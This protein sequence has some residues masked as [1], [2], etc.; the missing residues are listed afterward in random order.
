MKYIK[1]VDKNWIEKKGY[2]KKIF[3]DE[4]DLNFPGSLVQ[5]I[6]IKAGE[7]AGVHYHKKQTEIFYF[8]NGNGYFIVNGKRIDLEEGDTLVI[9]P[10][11]K[12]SVV[13]EGEE[14][15]IYIAF[16]LNYHPE[17]SYWE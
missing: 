7:T 12:H 11:D 14:D 5:Q 10:N 1:S 17:D 6:K 15:F 16:K 3:F 9:E 13:N 8:F 4:N 2:S